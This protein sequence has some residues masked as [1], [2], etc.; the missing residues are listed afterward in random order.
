[1]L[2]VDEALFEKYEEVNSF[3][4]QTILDTLLN[5]YMF[6]NHISI[7]KDVSWAIKSYVSA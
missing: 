6:G 3:Q 5:K 1:V 4:S 7:W 2:G